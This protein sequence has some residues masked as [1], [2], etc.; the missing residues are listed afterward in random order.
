MKKHNRMWRNIIT[1]AVATLV[2]AI[3]SIT[4][5]MAQ[6]TTPATPTVDDI[7]SIK[8]GI[9]T[10][11][12][13]LTGF[14][15]FIMQLGFAILETGMI[16]QTAGVNALLENFLEAGLGAIVWWLVGFGIAFGVDNGS[17]LFGTT[18][19]APG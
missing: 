5:G 6:D 12:V 2:L 9:D 3:F 7:T 14:L 13:L 19:F 17:G 15:V 18:L 10:V 8:I 16:R 11:W 4:R 1:M